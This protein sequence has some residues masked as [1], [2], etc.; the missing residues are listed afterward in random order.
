MQL[1]NTS[2][3]LVAE[4]PLKIIRHEEGQVSD[5]ITTED[6]LDFFPV[7]DE[8]VRPDQEK[9]INFTLT[10]IQEGVQNVFFQGPPGAGKSYVAYAIARYC[11]ADLGWKVR[12]FVPNRFLAQ[13]YIGDFSRY[14][15]RQLHSSRHYFCPEFKSSAVVVN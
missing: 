5:A 9:A 1:A 14:G 4:R 3:V 13:Q 12:I 10:R 11:A 2:S 8:G 7:T 6:W 15:M